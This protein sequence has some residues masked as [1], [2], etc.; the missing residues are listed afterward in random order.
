MSVED[1]KVGRLR[2]VEGVGTKGFGRVY[3]VDI[4]SILQD[5]GLSI[6]PDRG[7]SGVGRP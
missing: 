7:F 5:D 3:I 4:R 1:T 2:R 6:T